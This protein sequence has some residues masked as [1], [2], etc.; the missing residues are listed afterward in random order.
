VFSF[1]N[2][3]LINAMREAYAQIRSADILKSIRVKSTD[4]EALGN[5]NAKLHSLLLPRMVDV[6]YQ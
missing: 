2:V 6:A 1:I 4:Q 3:V 5:Y